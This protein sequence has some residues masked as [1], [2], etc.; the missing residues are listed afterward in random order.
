ML[1]AST[2]WVKPGPKSLSARVSQCSGEDVPIRTERIQKSKFAV[3]IHTARDGRWAF[4]CLRRRCWLILSVSVR[5][6]SVDVLRGLTTLP[7]ATAREVAGAFTVRQAFADMAREPEGDRE[8][9]APRPQP[10]RA[11]RD[12]GQPIG[13]LG[14]ACF[15]RHPPAAVRKD[16]GQSR[17]RTQPVA[18]VDRSS[19]S[20][21]AQRERLLHPGRVL[22]R[23][24]TTRHRGGV[25]L[26][27]KERKRGSDGQGN[28]RQWDSP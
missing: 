15:A 23:T 1:L 7:V 17:S 20:R 10:T 8:L 13:H 28:A 22:P 18:S 6:S 3:R 26:R 2:A 25:G 12:R 16:R 19:G 27:H 14:S 24:D 4:D 9:R 5:S 21:G 11:T